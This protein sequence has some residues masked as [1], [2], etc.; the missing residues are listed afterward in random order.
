MS[1]RPVN[2]GATLFETAGTRLG[3]GLIGQ[4]V[5]GLADIRRALGLHAEPPRGSIIPVEVQRALGLSA[6]AG[7]R[8]DL[9]R[10]PWPA[11]AC[12]EMH[13]GSYVIPIELSVD[14]GASDPYRV[15]EGTLTF[16]GVET[17]QWAVTEGQFGVMDPTS[18]DMLLSDT[19]LLVVEPLPLPSEEPA[20]AE[21][22]NVSTS[23][24]AIVGFHSP[25]VTYPGFYFTGG[26]FFSHNTLFR[27]WQ[28]CS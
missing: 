11:T 16:E 14:L 23:T 6:E 3:E 9:S 15:L 18:P 19:L 28:T 5:G 7:S 10:E 8:A 17:D 26:G 13:I 12:F 27:G 20:D 22:A 1:D 25:P 24:V 21:A 2:S 4:S